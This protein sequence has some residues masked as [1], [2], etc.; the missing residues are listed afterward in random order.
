MDLADLLLEALHEMQFDE[1]KETK[2]KD[3][4]KKK[5]FTISPTLDWSVAFSTFMAVTSYF[6][7]SWAFALLAFQ[8]IVL[9]LARDVGGQAWLIYDKV[10]RQAAAVNPGLDWHKREQDIWF[11]SVAAP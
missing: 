6:Y 8:S 7:P 4:A 2:A 3:E 11:M 10:F 1:A 9:N 5:K